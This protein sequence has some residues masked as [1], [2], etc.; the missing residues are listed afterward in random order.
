[1]ARPKWITKAGDLGIIAEREFYNLRLDAIDPD[2]PDS[3]RLTYSIVGGNLPRGL[4]LK[5][6]GF[7]EGIPTFR[8]VF[9]RGSPADVSENVV[10]R[11]CVRVQTE[12]GDVSDRTFTLTVSGQDVPRITS[13]VED[14][15]TSYDGV[16]FSHYIN[17]VDLDNEQLRWSV[18]SGSLPPGLTLDPATGLISGYFNLTSEE[19]N[20]VSGWQNTEWDMNPWDFNLRGVSKTFQFSIA[21]T[22]G[23]DYD[24]KTFTIKVISK[25]SMTADNVNNT[26]DT[27]TLLS[28]DVDN[29][30]NPVLLTRSQDLGLVL[31]DNYFAFKFDG[32]DFDGDEICYAPYY[33]GGFDNIVDAFDMGSFDSGDTPP[34]GLK[35]NENTGWLYGFIPEDLPMVSEYKIGI[36]VYKRDY[37]SYKSE[38][39][40]FTLT[41]IGDLGKFVKWV[42]PTHLGDIAN[43]EVS[44]LSIRATNDLGNQLYYRLVDYY[45]VGTPM[46]GKYFKTGDGITDIFNVQPYRTVE[47]KIDYGFNLTTHLPSDYSLYVD[48]VESL[49]NSDFY[50]HTVVYEVHE[51][52]TVA[53]IKFNNPPP[54]A[55]VIQLIVNSGFVSTT[56]SYSN[57]SGRLPQGLKL[58]E[59][60]LIVGKTSFNGF[61][62]DGGKCTFDVVQRRVGTASVSTTFDKNYYFTVEVYDKEGLINA[63]KTFSISVDLVNRV[64]Y[65]NLYGVALL[66]LAQRLELQQLLDTL[67]SDT[68]I[69]SLYRSGDPNFGVSKDIRLLIAA[70][71]FPA[72]ASDFQAAIARNHYLKKLYLGDIRV[73]RALN[74]DGTTRYEVVYAEVRDYLENTKGETLNSSINL[75]NIAIRP[76]FENTI[77]PNSIIN[78][79]NEVYKHIMQVNSLALPAWML[80]KQEN[81]LIPGLINAAVIC[82]VNPGEGEKLA[83][84]INRYVRSRGNFLRSLDFTLDRYVWDN[85]LSQYYD[86]TKMKFIGSNETTFDKFSLTAG[87]AELVAIVDFAVDVAFSEINGKTP[88]ALATQQIFDGIGTGFVGKSLVFAKQELFPNVGEGGTGWEKYL[89]TFD[90]T[91][92][93]SVSFDQMTLVPG[94]FDVDNEGNTLDERGGVYRITLVDGVI[95]LVLEKKVYPGQRIDVNRGGT[96]YGG[97]SLFYDISSKPGLIYP[98][99]S[100]L[101]DEEQGIQ[102]TFDNKGTRFFKNVDMYADPDVGDQYIKF[103]QVGVFE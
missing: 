30:R 71:L 90:Q 95:S 56:T 46:L 77:Y 29:R 34:P 6:D 66:P 103:P 36:T 89:T 98:E 24:V 21:V 102:T 94:Y 74:E 49:M 11:F 64:P 79:R 7:I 51:G 52:V 14:L 72:N 62:L 23:K 93:D 86:Q 57:S 70:G 8:K 63:T 67:N 32:F 101:Q 19:V 60:G 61:T 31:K 100:V 68:F 35:L 9:V 65:D 43:G 69:E 28:A 96:R 17:A 47:G 20:G 40:D 83:F 27:E 99:Y 97:K 82:Y 80:S 1:M 39:V 81:G 73:A 84:N 50:G 59:N 87:V 44:E 92:Y 58:L 42:S 3:S 37:P 33:E 18:K 22:D 45:S 76:D 53:Y 48:G 85:N 13:T 15:G 54:N 12:T 78:M 88:A 4:S 38:V 55:S 75:G 2:S 10:S 26:V 41:I 5:T 25:D 91:G 16:Y